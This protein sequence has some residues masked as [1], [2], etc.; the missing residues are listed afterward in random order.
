MSF[1]AFGGVLRKF[2][3]LRRC[4]Q[5]EGWI[6]ADPRAAVVNGS[7]RAALT[8]LRRISTDPRDDASGH[9]ADNIASASREFLWIRIWRLVYNL[10]KRSRRD[11]RVDFHLDSRRSARCHG[12]L[13]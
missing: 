5:A 8:M 7:T 13:A 4:S 12:F 3:G 1:S 10:H 9:L 2:L 11:R 6:A